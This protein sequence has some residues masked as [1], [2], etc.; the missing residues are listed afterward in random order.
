[1]LTEKILGNIN[2]GYTDFTDID[3]VDFEWFEVYKKLHKKISSKGR[4]VSI[5]FE[6]SILT[7]GLKDGD[8]LGIEDKTAVVVNILPCEALI[9]T[10]DH[11]HLIPKICYEIGNKHAPLFY[12]NSENEF[13]TPYNEPTKVL[14]EKIGAKVT[15]DT[16]KLNFN[17]IISAT[18]SSHSH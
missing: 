16:A 3:Y 11:H 18:V 4:E 5:K 6:N 8:I 17:H 15:V 2:S 13:V 9:V 1:M 7:T 10:T 14:L 12:G